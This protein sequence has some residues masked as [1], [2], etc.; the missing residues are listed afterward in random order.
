MGKRGHQ[1]GNREREGCRPGL[2]LSSSESLS[3]SLRS[4]VETRSF[5]SAS[6]HVTLR[7]WS[8]VNDHIGIPEVSQFALE[9]QQNAAQW[10]RCQ[11]VRTTSMCINSEPK[12]GDFKPVYK[13]LQTHV[14][15]QYDSSGSYQQGS[16][17]CAACLC[18][19][20]WTLRACVPCSPLA[21]P[22]EDC[23]WSQCYLHAC[24]ARVIT[25]W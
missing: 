8:L 14:L 22:G 7:A 16:R 17:H 23:T 3:L 11:R 21:S 2:S 1:G 9:A 19:G 5:C 12:K 15:S 20:T 24:M 13:Q 6:Q 25:G 4:T 10:T 18:R